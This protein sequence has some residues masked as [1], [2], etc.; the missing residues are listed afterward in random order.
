MHRD[1][2]LE[3]FEFGKDC[4]LSPILFLFDNGEIAPAALPVH[5][6]LHGG[7]QYTMV[8]SLKQL[9]YDDYISLLSHQVF[10]K[11]IENLYDMRLYQKREIQQLYLW[12]MWEL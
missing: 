4:R 12:G 8:F 2:I 11:P 6:V 1:N 5:A 3:E 9:N 10:I 7:S